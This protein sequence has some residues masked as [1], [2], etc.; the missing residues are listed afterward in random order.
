[1]HHS[2]FRVLNNLISMMAKDNVE[3]CQNNCATLAVNYQLT[4]T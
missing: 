3:E 4:E 1:M 2:F